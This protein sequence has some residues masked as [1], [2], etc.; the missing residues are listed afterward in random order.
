MIED[1]RSHA[2]R[3]GSQIQRL[4]AAVV[5]P[6]RAAVLRKEIRIRI[7]GLHVHGLPDGSTLDVFIG[8]HIH[9]LIRRDAAGGIDGDAGKP[10]VRIPVRVHRIHG[11][12][13]DIRKGFPVL[14]VN[15]LFLLLVLFDMKELS[16]AHSGRY[17][18]H[19][20]VEAQLGMLI[21]AGG[22]PRLGGKESCLIHIFLV[23]RNQHAAA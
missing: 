3:R 20:I 12:G 19:T 7:N 14:P 22:I 16:S 2:L 17:I 8:K 9:H 18:G 23:C 1:L 11:D 21:I 6:L 10:V 13:R 5:R 4:H 15:L